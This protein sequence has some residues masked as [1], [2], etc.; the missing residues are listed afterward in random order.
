MGLWSSWSRLLYSVAHLSYR[1]AS[2]ADAHWLGRRGKK[3]LFGG[4]WLSLSK[5]RG[6]EVQSRDRQIGLGSVS[7]WLLVWAAPILGRILHLMCLPGRPLLTTK[8]K[9]HFPASF[10]PRDTACKPGFSHHAC[11]LRTQTWPLVRSRDCRG[12]ILANMAAMRLI[13]FQAASTPDPGSSPA[14]VGGS[15]HA[16]QSIHAQQRNS[17]AVWEVAPS[18]VIS[19][20]QCLA[21]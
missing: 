20:P 19:K 14:S 16:Q 10:V 5:S 12:S 2:Q 21:L 7:N 13:M 11:L 3:D 6:T 18:C 15:V 9:I 4:Q 8:V 1:N 17:C